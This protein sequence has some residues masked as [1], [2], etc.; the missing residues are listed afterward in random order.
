MTVVVIIQQVTTEKQ[1]KTKKASPLKPC[2]LV[3]FPIKILTE[4]I[5]HQQSM[6][7][8]SHLKIQHRNFPFPLQSITSM[9]QWCTLCWSDSFLICHVWDSS[10]HLFLARWTSTRF[11]YTHT[12]A[13]GCT[14]VSFLPF[15][16][17]LRGYNIS[18]FLCI[19]HT[20]QR[21]ADNGGFKL[22]R[23]QQIAF[24]YGPPTEQRIGSSF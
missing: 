13:R 19:C 8:M 18:L 7:S 15:S 14:A 5:S 24:S 3:N 1:T 2:Q 9:P 16:P 21:T 17:P 6:K 4:A 11:Y 12:P 23:R 10:H 22:V 20:R